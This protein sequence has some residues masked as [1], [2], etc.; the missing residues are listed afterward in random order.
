MN[1][2]QKLQIQQIFQPTYN[3]EIHE[4]ISHSHAS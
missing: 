2:S 3:F 1:L 4:E